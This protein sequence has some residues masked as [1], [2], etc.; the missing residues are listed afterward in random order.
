M[1]KV[2]SIVMTRNDD[3]IIE[4]WVKKHVKV[5]ENI[6]V[7]DGSDGDFTKNLCNKYNIL[8]TRDPDPT[9]TKPF[10]EQYLRESGYNLLVNA[11]V[12]QIG[13]WIVCSQ[14]DEWYYHDPR[15]VIKHVESDVDVS[16]VIA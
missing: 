12:L 11:G 13:D 2:H 16:L 9:P 15:K 10:H 4:H 14:S 8:Y 3:L 5:F 7:V 6:S 1:V